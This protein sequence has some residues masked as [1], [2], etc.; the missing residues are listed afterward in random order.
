MVKLYLIFYFI[1]YKK[2]YITI[3]VHRKNGICGI[4]DKTARILLERNT[5]NRTACGYDDSIL[6]QYNF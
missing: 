2:V 4:D 1:S 6:L 5:L 3:I